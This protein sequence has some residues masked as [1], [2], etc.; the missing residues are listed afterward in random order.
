[1]ARFEESKDGPFNWYIETWVSK[2]S[3]SLFYSKIFW[4]KF[5]DTMI[6]IIIKLERLILGQVF[7]LESTTKL[8]VICGLLAENSKDV[9]TSWY[10]KNKCNKCKTPFLKN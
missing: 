1:M 9:K 7:I 4:I 10:T 5:K 6:N 3:F 2:K 8:C